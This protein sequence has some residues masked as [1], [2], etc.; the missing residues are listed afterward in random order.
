MLA[1][2]ACWLLRLPS[3]RVSVSARGRAVA[4]V[5]TMIIII[6]VAGAGRAAPSDEPA[7]QQHQPGVRAAR[8]ARAGAPRARGA[9]RHVLARLLMR[10]SGAQVREGAR[11][12][13]ATASVRHWVAAAGLGTRSGGGARRK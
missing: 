7:A 13:G 8:E 2:R 4:M 10:A 6:I 5:R 1:R 11:A 12:A 3:W 9:T